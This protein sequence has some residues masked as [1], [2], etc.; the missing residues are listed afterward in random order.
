MTATPPGPGP[1]GSASG[2]PVTGPAAQ[3]TGPPGAAA[4]RALPGAAAPTAAAAPSAAVAPSAAAA[5]SG[6]PRAGVPRAVARL[7]GGSGRRIRLAQ[8]VCWQV[9]VV[10]VL[11]A[12]RQEP[13]LLL[14]AV[15]AATVL[16]VPTVVPW[17]GRW[18]YLWLPVWLAY[19]G[20]RRD[21]VPP[22]PVPGR[23]SGS[24]PAAA[25]DPRRSLI[26]FVAPGAAVTDATVDGETIAV[27]T[28][29]AGLA[30]VLELQ[31]DDH[32]LFAAQFRSS[33]D[34]VSLLPVVE[35]DP[36]PATAQL[37]VRVEPA[38]AALAGTGAALESYRQLTGGRVPADRRCWLAVQIPR[39][40]EL[41]RDE[42]LRPLLV[43]AVRRAR[44]RW[45][46][47]GLAARL[48]G[49][50][51]LLNAAW[52]VAGL[53]PHPAG[54]PG[55][56]GHGH[57]GELVRE[58]W[59]GW[60]SA[61]RPQASFRITRWPTGRWSVDQVLLGLPATVT[62]GAAVVRDPERAARGDL[63]IEAVVRAAAADGAA[64]ASVDARLSALLR[65]AGGAVE[66]LDGR[67]RTTMAAT[68]P[69]GWVSEP[70]RH[71]PNQ[72]RGTTEGVLA[73]LTPTIGG[74]GLMIGH[75]RYQVPVVLRLL[76][77]EPTRVVLTGGLGFAQLLV[78]RLV[79]LNA[80]IIVHTAR[81]P[82]WA[83][84]VQYTGIGPGSL[85]FVPPGSH[86]PPAATRGQPEVVVMDVGPVGWPH[87]EWRSTRRTTVV[88]R[89]EVTPVDAELLAGADLV[90]L[91][92]L[93]PAEAA[94]A[95]PAAGVPQ[96][97]T[98]MS[99]ISESMVTMAS[100]GVVRW[101]TLS[102]TDI[103]LRTLGTP[104]RFPG[105]AHQ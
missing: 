49:P 98:W 8:V 36:L 23:A 13:V 34:P 103:E 54:R 77:S 64:L 26:D 59:D 80:R 61:D 19:I 31:P 42:E 81:P 22:V 24:A 73:D 83:R 76:R 6:V 91:Q 102:P 52:A 35:S 41:L 75:D 7:A 14:A 4:P 63:G 86:I 87:L 46:R 48:L 90:L 97:E 43:N 11:V 38:L 9:A 89:H 66:R 45:R 92:Q 68:L 50:E 51:D 67:H 105:A 72:S 28:H 20:R 96:A 37:L 12:S 95:A 88:V 99:R 55:P 32:T 29:Q 60:R 71:P 44:R 25:P 47:N 5:R 30:A 18:L 65:A 79:A 62:L 70:G 39:T 21:L 3:L 53:D 58:T 2:R 74:G 10:L 94:V 78:F 57:G 33:P 40:P 84:F 56:D 16:V 93:L 85:V 15:A 27:V 100:R 17:R 69:L 104:E 1:V 101:A 82:D